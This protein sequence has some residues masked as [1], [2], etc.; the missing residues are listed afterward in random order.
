[1]LQCVWV[2]KYVFRSLLRVRLL[3]SPGVQLLGHRVG[4]RLTLSETSLAAS[5]DAGF[6]V[7]CDHFRNAFPLLAGPKLAPHPHQPPDTLYHV[8]SVFF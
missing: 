3:V 5:G 1:M 2:R 7:K 8:I 4:Q 6:G